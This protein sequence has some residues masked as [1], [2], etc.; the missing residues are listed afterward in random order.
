[1]ADPIG[2]L[3]PA[4]LPAGGNRMYQEFEIDEETARSSSHYELD[5]EF[6]YLAIG[7][8]WHTYSSFLWED[9]FTATQAQEKKLDLLADLMQLEPGMRI[10]DVGCGWGGPLVYF[11]KKY[12]VSG[13]GI[14]VTPGQIEAARARAAR[15]GVD[16]TFEMVHWQNLP[17]TE[18]YD[19]IYTDEC[20]VHFR[21]LGGFFRKCHEALKP[22]QLMVHKE[23]H[24]THSSESRLGRLSE[25]VNKVYAYTGN[26]ITLHQELR[27]LDES[28]FRLENVVT[29]PMHNY[30]RTLDFWDQNMLDHRDRLR[31]LVGAET[32]KDVRLYLKAMRYLFTRLPVFGLHVVASR[33]FG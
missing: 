13:H 31:E 21:D 7:G 27:L 1:M 33:R 14:A 24:L 17:S 10:L 25:H 8:E 2:D 16:A 3:S 29:L 5:S 6:F 4:T 26:Y 18:R 19:V 9:G 15:H 11:C 28:G 30:Q 32:F 20:M 22:G 23:L 12:G